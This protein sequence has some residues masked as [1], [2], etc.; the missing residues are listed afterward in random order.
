M[1]KLLFVAAFFGVLAL[2]SQ[3]ARQDKAAF[4]GLTEMEAR[5]RIVERFPEK[6]PEERRDAIADTIVSKMRDRGI[7]SIDELEADE[8]I[9][10]NNTST[11]EPA[12]AV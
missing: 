1:K 5:N 9:E 4:Q 11:Q 7:L 10:L 12:D 2:I 3:K 6:V 8:T